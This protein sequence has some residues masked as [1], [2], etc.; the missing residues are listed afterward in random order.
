M[1]P[2]YLSGPVCNE[3][4]PIARASAEQ[5]AAELGHDLGLFGGKTRPS[6]FRSTHTPDRREIRL[7][8]RRGQL[9]ARVTLQLRGFSYSL[10][11]LRALLFNRHGE[12]S[13]YSALLFYC[14][15]LLRGDGASERVCSRR[16][17]LFVCSVQR[18][19]RR[20]AEPAGASAQ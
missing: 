3:Q 16:Q 13:A 12:L 20:R 15:L 17:R 18:A 5:L 2:S 19:R 6:K 11:V 14:V 7:C 1:M 8:H 10:L 9:C 4:S